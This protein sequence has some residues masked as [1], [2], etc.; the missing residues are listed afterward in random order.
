MAKTTCNT[1][2]AADLTKN[3]ADLVVGGIEKTGY[4]LNRLDIDIEATKASFITGSNG[5]Y[6]SL[7]VKTGKKGYKSTNLNN[8]VST[9]VDGLYVNKFQH[10]LTGALLDDGDVPAS[11][12]DALSSKEGEFVAVIVNR[13]VDLNRTTNSGSSAFQIIG[14]DTPLT[15]ANQEI[16]N[17]KASA[18]TDGGWAF[19][20]GTSEPSSRNYWYAETYTA[21]RALFDALGTVAE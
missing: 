8:M 2:L 18:D 10:V 6:E 12:I 9:K 19:A 13:F 14:L 20:L 1:K 3:C 21:T 16:K 5:L 11:I 7:V 17:D 4:I 15:S